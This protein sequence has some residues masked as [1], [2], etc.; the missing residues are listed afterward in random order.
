MAPHGKELSL[1][2]KKTIILMHQ[3][4]QGY[5]KIAN[6]LK[7]SKSTVAKI[8]QK[9]KKTGTL[10]AVNGRS[11]RPRK[12][13]VQ[14]ERYV[15]RVVDQNPRESA[16]NLANVVSEA[17]GISVSSSTVRRT[18]HQVNLH[19]RRP[20]KKPLLKPRHKLARLQFA[21]EYSDRPMSFWESILW[22]DKT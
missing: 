15:T 16:S 12:L 20:R 19:S 3:D 17:T 22:S 11:G 10:V 8:V 14:S 1:D 6:T 4:K 7:L 2:L 18:L 21:Q 5:I 9:Y 13:T